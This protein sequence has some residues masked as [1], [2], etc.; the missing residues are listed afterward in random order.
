MRDLPGFFA[1]DSRAQALPAFLTELAGHLEAE[2]KALLKDA[3]VLRG[4]VE[5]ASSVIVLPQQMGKPGA[6]VRELVSA[7]SLVETA[8][9]LG[10]ASFKMQGI[11]IVRDYVHTGA[12]MAD[13]HRA[14]QILMNLLS[15]AC[16]ALHD[17][18]DGNK[19]IVVRTACAG[20]RVR[21]AVVD[22]GTGID[23]Q[24]LPTLFNQGFTTK[25]DGHGHGLHSSANWA[26]ELGGELTCHSDGPGCGAT[27]TLELPLSSVQQ[28][29][30]VIS[31]SEPVAV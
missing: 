13:R 8:L 4:C 17:S 6:E 20:N 26:R 1:R 15:N 30:D 18:S 22:N 24:H 19:R 25:R 21:I 29:T 3:E 28:E 2:H 27:F 10:R 23:P 7:S 5:H 14:L 16:D 11:G 12:V 9:K 31:A